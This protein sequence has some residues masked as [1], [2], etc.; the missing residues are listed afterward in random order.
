VSALLVFQLFNY[1]NYILTLLQC[2]LSI[3]SC[4]QCLRSHRTCFG[5][6]NTADLLFRDQSEDVASRVQRSKPQKH[7]ELGKKEL[8]TNCGLSHMTSGWDVPNYSNA[9]DALQWSVPIS[10]EN[11]ALCFFLKNYSSESSKKFGSVYNHI[12]SIY[13]SEAPDSPLLNIITALGL[14][15]MSHHTNTSGMEVAACAWYNKALRKIN[16]SIRDPELVKTD[17]TLL[18]VLLLGLYEVGNTL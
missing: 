4:G 12:P 10:V 18:V 6:R 7:A 17:H 5:Y 13:S 16:H 2:D 14:A 8:D 3:P 15:G 1:V 11:Q 9:T